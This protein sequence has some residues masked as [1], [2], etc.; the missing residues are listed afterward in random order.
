MGTLLQGSREMEQVESNEG[1]E[2]VD[3]GLYLKGRTN[4]V[5]DRLTTKREV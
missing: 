5:P 2:K 4:R 3:S 1:G